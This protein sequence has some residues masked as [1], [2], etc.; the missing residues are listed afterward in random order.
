MT[1]FSTTAF[2]ATA[3]ARETSPEIMEA[4]AFLARNEAEAVQL[5]EIGYSPA[6]D[7]ADVQEIVTKNGRLDAEDFCWGAA[8]SR[9]AAA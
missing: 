6:G 5:W 9:W 8:G 7:V 2:I 3:A 4:I 1:K